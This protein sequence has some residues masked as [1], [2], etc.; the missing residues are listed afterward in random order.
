VSDQTEN[1]TAPSAEELKKAEQAAKQ[2]EEARKAAKAARRAEKRARRAARVQKIARFTPV[3]LRES[4]G[5]AGAVLLS[6]AF[7]AIYP[8]A[9]YG[10]GGLLLMLGATVSARNAR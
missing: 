3:L 9:G 6:Y 5:I 2:Q 1:A 4:A 8:P 7:W 10:V